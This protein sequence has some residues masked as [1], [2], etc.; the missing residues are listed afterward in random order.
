MVVFTKA[1]NARFRKIGVLGGMGPE[2]T[3]LLY[4]KIIRKCQQELGAQLDEDFPEIII[5]SLP[6]PNVVLGIKKPESIVPLLEY[7]VKKLES[8]G[9]Q[10]IAVPCNTVQYFYPEMQGATSVKVL[11]IV[12]E[13][14]RSA[15]E[16]GYR[17]LGLLATSAT[18]DNDIYGR[19]A[20]EIG[21]E[22]LVPDNVLPGLQSAVTEAI[23]NILAGKVLESDRKK[24]SGII[25]EMAAIG[26]DAVI[27]G[28]TELP[29]LMRTEDSVIP[30]IDSLDALAESTIRNSMEE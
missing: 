4:Q 21:L 25:A 29:I 20:R 11:N 7:A 13:T 14:V 24:L 12:E 30:L 5:C 16:K 22:I 17:K 15:G 2:A 10:V 8:A 3:A 9:S 18:V 6:I 26:A 28:C 19:L 23:M 1:G 27:L